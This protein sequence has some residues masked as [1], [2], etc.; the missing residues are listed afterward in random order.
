MSDG[1]DEYDEYDDVVLTDEEIAMQDA[2]DRF[3][4]MERQYTCQGR[5][6]HTDKGR[7]ARM[8]YNHSYKGK[9]C[10]RR[11]T[12]KRVNSGKNAEKCRNY[13]YRKKLALGKE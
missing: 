7:L 3:V 11:K 12:Q 13:Y 6:N 4:T 10:E 8:R 1:F 9:E 5:Y 2:F